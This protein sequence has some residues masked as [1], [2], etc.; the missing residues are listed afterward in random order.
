MSH[1]S[2]SIAV[3]ELSVQKTLEA[4]WN[5]EVGDKTETHVLGTIEDAVGVVR[6]LEG[7]AQVFV[8]GSLH[9]VGGVLEVLE[10][11]D[12]QM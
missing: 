6:G 5:E 1:T 8:T 12:L 11:K 10:S 3:A 2:D 4:A 9:L 7:G